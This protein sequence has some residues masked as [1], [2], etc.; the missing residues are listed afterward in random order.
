MATTANQPPFSARHRG[1]HRQVNADFPASAKNGLMHLLMDLVDENTSHI[2]ELW[3]ENFNVLLAWHRSN[4]S[5]PNSKHE[6]S[7]G[8]C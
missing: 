4:M 1:P 3:R 2:G 6:K 7:A 8:G 5:A